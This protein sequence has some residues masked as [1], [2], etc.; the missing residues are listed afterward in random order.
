MNKQEQIRKYLE[1]MFE[2]LAQKYPNFV[3]AD[4]KQR[5]SDMFLNR[6]ADFDIVRQEIDK[7]VVKAIRDHQE[8]LKKQEIYKKMREKRYYK[9]FEK[10]N[11]E[12]RTFTEIQNAYNKLREVLGEN[13][14]KVF[15]G[16]GALPYLLLN[17]ESGR[18]HDDIDSGCL[19]SDIA[20]LRELFKNTPYYNAEW[21]SLTYAKDGNDYGFELNIDGVPVGISPFEFKDG[22][23]VS[24]GF[25]PYTKELKFRDVPN[26]NFSDYFTAYKGVDGRIYYTVSLEYI[27]RSKDQ[28]KRPKDIEDSKV[29]EQIGIRQDVYDRLYVP[30]IQQ[31]SNKYLDD[32]QKIQE[33]MSKTMDTYCTEFLEKKG[34][35]NPLSG[36]S[37]EK[38]KL[39]LM[40]CNDEKEYA[41]IV[42]NYL[43]SFREG[44]LFL[45]KGKDRFDSPSPTEV[46]PLYVKQVDGKYIISATK[47]ENIEQ[48]EIL[49]INGIPIEQ[50]LIDKGYQQDVEMK[51]IGTDGEPIVPEFHIN[52]DICFITMEN[53]IPVLINNIPVEEAQELKKEKEIEDS[54]NVICG[55]TQDG[56]PYVRIKKLDRETKEQAEQQLVEFAKYLK[57]QQQTDLVIDIRGNGGGT[58]EYIG[59][60]GYFSDDTYSQILTYEILTGMTE[61]ETNDNLNDENI[62]DIDATL[63]RIDNTPNRK[64]DSHESIIRDGQSTITNRLLL[65]D[66]QVFSSADKMT[67]VMQ[68]SG[69][70]TVVGAELTAGDGEGFSIH[71]VD[72]PLLREQ[73]LSITMPS[74]MGLDYSHFQTI[75]DIMTSEHE[76]NTNLGQIMEQAKEQKK[77]K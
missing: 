41:E 14:S 52:E 54:P 45:K 31:M 68:N 36:K 72:T 34:I 39:Q 61:E 7:A 74:S 77:L 26:A 67:K 2:Q 49:S 18:L 8:Q 13:I 9:N 43:N 40:A 62:E 11:R 64:T 59:Y 44:H 42:S 21:D 22:G 32:F 20:M 66:G 75:P 71:Q 25:D 69:F 12:S 4:R 1:Q 5:A 55:Y 50:Y 19:S 38:V 33:L 65:V 48:Q 57:A 60:L 24:Y 37:L 10:D 73:G 35:E 63:E 29:I 51:I 76:M 58:D 3:T 6:E 23:M 30:E 53:E 28:I 56:I 15:V 27:K 16:G 70:A 17:R 46:T 47:N